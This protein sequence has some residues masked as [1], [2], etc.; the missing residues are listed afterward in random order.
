MCLIHDV[1]WKQDLYLTEKGM[2]C[3]VRVFSCRRFWRL[4]GVEPPSRRAAKT[5]RC[6]WDHPRFSQVGSWE[7]TPKFGTFGRRFS[8]SKGGI[9]WYCLGWSVFWRCIII[10]PNWA[11]FYTPWFLPG[12][13]VKT[14]VVASAWFDLS[15]D[16][17]FFC[18]S[19][20]TVYFCDLNKHSGLLEGI[21][22][23]NGTTWS[24]SY[25]GDSC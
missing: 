16:M 13:L 14:S 19:H 3:L 24:H 23:D 10:R 12:I 6:P 20:Q 4:N 18:L 9:V 11:N 22:E 21:C 1:T 7:G 25:I 15:F 5:P 8:F 17:T 2:A